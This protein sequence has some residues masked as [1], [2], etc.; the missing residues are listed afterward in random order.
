MLHTLHSHK[1]WMY[2]SS[3]AWNH[4]RCLRVGESPKLPGCCPPTRVSWELSSMPVCFDS[5]SSFVKQPVAD[6]IYS[7]RPKQEAGERTRGRLGFKARIQ[8]VPLCLETRFGLCFSVW[9]GLFN[10]SLPRKETTPPSVC[11][12]F[13]MFGLER[14]SRRIVFRLRQQLAP[15][16][17]SMKINP[18]FLSSR[19]KSCGNWTCGTLC[20]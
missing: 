3:G 19:D 2:T 10:N 16:S 11:C 14:E 9:G 7:L 6:W 12:S 13:R 15:A 5:D 8:I 17:I 4:H 20:P 18:D 1:V